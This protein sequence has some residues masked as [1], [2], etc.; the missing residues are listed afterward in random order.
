MSEKPE[1]FIHTMGGLGN[2]LFQIAAAYAHCKRNKLEFKLSSNVAHDKHGTH[3]DSIFYKCKKYF[4]EYKDQPRWHEPAFHYVPI[5]AGVTALGG[6]FQSSKYFSDCNENIRNLFVL[7][8]KMQQEIRAKYATI[9]DEPCAVLHIRR[10][11]YVWLPT[12][13]C[14]LNED[15]YRRAVALLRDREPGARLLV[16]SDD[17]PWARNLDFLS[18]ATFVDE[19]DAASALYL[20]SQFEHYVIS[21]S[22]FS[23]WAAWLGATAKTVIA[24]D[25]WFG[26]D[27]PQ[28]FQDIYE[29]SWLL[30]PVTP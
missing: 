2:Q 28:D 7:P 17:L 15:Y 29:P 21:N 22:S 26:P 24:P 27:G 14:I 4:G 12:F 16:F 23:W 19:P 8:Y 30:C 20:M 6:Y 9:L 18:G 10:G 25:R 5:P 11:D 1:C 3:W 13:H